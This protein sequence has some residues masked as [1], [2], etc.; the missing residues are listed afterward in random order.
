MFEG[1]TTMPVMTITAMLHNMATIWAR[2]ITHMI[3]VVWVHPEVAEFAA[4]S[5]SWL[6]GREISV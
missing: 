1:A 5:A 6:T 3:A 2:W 4:T